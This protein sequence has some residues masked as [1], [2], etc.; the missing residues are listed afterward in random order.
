M[1]E[2]QPTS[3]QQG[4][5][6]SWISPIP[7]PLQ[8]V[9]D[10][11][12]LVIY[13]ANDLPSRSPTDHPDDSS[14]P[15]LHV[16]TTARDAA[17]GWPSFN[18][19]CL[20]W[21]AYLRFAGVP[22]RLAPSTNH[23]SP[24]GSLPF[25]LPP[26]PSAPAARLD[27]RPLLPIPSSRLATYAAGHNKN[28]TSPEEDT[29]QRQQ[30]A[31]QALLNTPIRS[32]WLYTLYLASANEPLL[33]ALY[34]RPVSRSFLVQRTILSQLRHAARAEIAKTT[35]TPSTPHKSPSWSI[36]LGGEEE[37]TSFLRDLV[38]WAAIG[39]QPTLDPELIYAQAQVAFEAFEA[40]LSSS[41]SSWFFNAPRPTLFD[42]AVFSY[43]YLLLAPATSSPDGDNGQ[44]GDDTLRRIVRDKCPRLVAHARRV[45]DEYWAD[46]EGVRV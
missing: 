6:S 13:P 14:L 33:R 28:K 12:P 23:A 22:H 21:Q 4:S 43:T 15:T 46:V 2:A 19:S 7:R 39:G 38:T 17:R 41:S 30:Q 35:S 11:V 10:S 36:S 29:N 3:A 27:T 1:T 24:T 18:P 42:A 34:L 16:F 5:S 26:L 31:Y 8:R 44:W 45:L 9:F 32:A 37:G 40:A 20:K 25:L